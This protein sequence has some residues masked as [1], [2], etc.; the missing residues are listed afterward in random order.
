MCGSVAAETPILSPVGQLPLRH[1]EDHFV[2]VADGLR[3]FR[4]DCAGSGRRSIIPMPTPE[5]APRIES[6]SRKVKA[7]GVFAVVVVV[8][9]VVTLIAFGRGTPGRSR[10]TSYPAQATPSAAG[11]S[12]G[13]SGNARRSITVLGIGD[14]VTAG[15]NCDCQAFVEL[16]AADLAHERGLKT[17]AIN[18][19]ASSGGTSSQ[20]LA[21]LTHP[22]TLRGRVAESDILLV[23]IGANDLYSPVG[24]WRSSG[25]D[26]TCYS[27]VAENVGRNVGR[28]VS[29]ARAARPDHPATILVT[30]Y[31]NVFPDG[32]VGIAEKGASF[33]SWSDRLTRSANQQIRRSAQRAGATCVDLYEPFKGDGS[34]NPTSLLAADGDHPNSAGHQ[35]IASTLLANMPLRI[36]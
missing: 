30:D 18:L 13:A 7:V 26:T 1:Q 5:R 14:S 10:S 35:L 6:N 19:G 22:G 16:Y 8:G 12:T 20:L 15:S 27:P 2:A 24:T 9:V 4:T 3:T 21:S 11:I 32:D 29:A 36:P 34:R 28:I 25:C 23:T 17:S 33:Q 31:W